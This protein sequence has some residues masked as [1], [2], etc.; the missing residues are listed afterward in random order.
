MGTWIYWECWKCKRQYKVY[1]VSEALDTKF[2]RNGIRYP[3]CNRCKAKHPE[4][5]KNS[6]KLK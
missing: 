3:L 5:M 2:L 4:L 6:R 1:K